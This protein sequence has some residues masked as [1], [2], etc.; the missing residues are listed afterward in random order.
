M[1]TGPTDRR[2]LMTALGGVAAAV[3]AGCLTDQNPGGSATNTT[4]AHPT[5]GTDG[6]S[7]IE[8]AS[9]T[10]SSFKYDPGRT[11]SLSTPPPPEDAAV[12]WSLKP[13][14]QNGILIQ[15]P[16]RIEDTLY[17]GV[18]TF[19]HFPGAVIAV[20]ATMGELRWQQDVVANSTPLAFENGTI[21]AGVQSYEKGT[22]SKFVALDAASGEYRWSKELETASVTA[23]ATIDGTVLTTI[24]GTI[25]ALDPSDGSV[26]W[27][28]T[29]PADYCS[30][31]AVSNGTAF[32]VMNSSDDGQ[33]RAVA[34]DIASGEQRWTVET[35]KVPAAPAVT[36]G[37]LYTGERE[38]TVRASTVAD[39]TEVWSTSLGDLE[40]DPPKLTVAHGRVYVNTKIDGE[41]VFALNAEN[42][43]VEWTASSLGM[44]V[45]LPALREHIALPRDGAMAF[46]DAA[47]GSESYEISVEGKIRGVSIAG[48]ELYL[49]ALTPGTLHLRCVRS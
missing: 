22:P 19:G 10:I 12:D 16:L 1:T 40:P 49:S 14:V 48:G 27:T 34:V 3:L 41:N 7:N 20:D 6:R 45:P 30:P 32:A 5:T 37:V 46:V 36:D 26:V 28:S 42:G 38:N 35:G 39:G 2:A 13:E 9:T 43:D 47:D 8:N 11:G 23:P 29:E 15:W 31:V 25:T 21:Y 18:G 17:V 4:D 44:P 24:N 33:H